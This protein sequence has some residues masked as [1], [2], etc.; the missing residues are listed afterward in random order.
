MI[1]GCITL[2]VETRP[3]PVTHACSLDNHDVISL[4]VYDVDGPEEVPAMDGD[5]VTQV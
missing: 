1:N 3:I 4:K 2:P 5:P